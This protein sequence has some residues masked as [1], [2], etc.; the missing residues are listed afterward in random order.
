MSTGTL[1]NITSLFRTVYFSFACLFYLVM[2][3]VIIPAVYV[4]YRALSCIG[5]NMEKFKAIVGKLWLQVTQS[6]LCI[7]IGDNTYI[8]YKPLPEDQM[9]GNTLI[10]SNHTSYV[11]W[12]YLWSLLLKTGRESISFIAKEAVGAF[13]P[14]R[15]G[16][17]MLNFVLLTRKMEDDQMRLKK[18]CSVL[19][20]SNNY[21]LVIFPEGT[22]I[23]QDTKKKDEIFLK[24]ELENRGLLKT[25]SPEEIEEKKIH[26]TI[27]HSLNKVFQEVIFPRVKGFKILVDELKPTLKNIMDCTIYLNMHGSD[28]M[29]PSDHFTL[30]NIIL[31]RCSRIQAL[32]IC[33]N[34]KFD[35][36]IAENSSEWIY[37]RF[38]KKDELLKQ[39]KMQR[40]RK[41]NMHDICTEYKQKGYTIKRLHPSLSVTILLSAGSLVI[42]LPCIFLSYLVSVFLYKY[43]AS[44]Y[45]TLKT[46]YNF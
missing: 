2:C 38:A 30:T 6:L 34:I 20:K 14:L 43:L 32:I 3:I 21:N 33:E 7:L 15:L 9:M 13:Y 26:T 22:F 17:D 37:N 4:T 1:R 5:I 27:P 25:L 46:L 28:M 8:L 45:D 39:L 18:A 19:H 10:I 24:K 16:I 42:I 41:D 29:Y 36:K 23:D 31:G 40:A 35:A 11:D 44:P 12:I